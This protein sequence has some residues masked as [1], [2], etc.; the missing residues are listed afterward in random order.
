MAY[1]IKPLVTEKMT[2]I[3]EKQNKFGFIVRP[4]ANKLE[5]RKEV[6]ALYNVTVLDVN[7]MNY[8]GKNKSRYTR[9][10]LIKG[11]TNAYKKAIVTLKD[12]DTIDFYSN[13]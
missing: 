2:A 11:R 4:E 9:A 12:G 7:T 10:G 6:E 3:T 8:A 13:I 5:I 1:I